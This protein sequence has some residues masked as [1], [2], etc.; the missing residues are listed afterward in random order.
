[1]KN[2]MIFWIGPV[3]DFIA[4]ARRSRDLWYGSWMLSE[5]SRAA[6]KEVVRLSGSLIFPADTQRTIS[7]PNKILATVTT[8]PKSFA[9]A[10][11]AAVASRMD[12][13]VKDALD[14]VKSHTFN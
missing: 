2:L 9:T 4:T 3:Q 1:M 14:R 11:K 13:L 10:I 6:A 7:I 8:D 5:L 12:E